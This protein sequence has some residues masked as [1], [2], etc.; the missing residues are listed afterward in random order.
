MKEMPATAGTSHPPFAGGE[1]LGCH[2][3]HASD[4]SGMLVANESSLCATCHAGAMKGFK[5]AKSK[6]A[7]FEKGACTS[8]HNPHKAKLPKLLLALSPDLCLN[9]HKQLRAKEATEKVHSPAQKDCQVCHK[10]HFAPERAL[11]DQPVQS[12]CSQCHN[13][14]A[15]SFGK[16][17]L[18]IS[19]SAM[20]CVSCHNPHTSKDPKFFKE[21]IHPP[22]AGR[23]CDDCHLVQKQ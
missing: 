14:E 8:C 22:F 7:P 6:H 3:P 23:S 13:Y 5:E 16:A 20:D 2:N 10:P 4:V 17:H 1:C 18:G 9:C 19:A 11:L 15:A 12:L 21:N